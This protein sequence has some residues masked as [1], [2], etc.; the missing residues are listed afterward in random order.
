M[1]FP[2]EIHPVSR[3]VTAS[4]IILLGYHC[5]ANPAV[6]F[7][8]FGM[9]LFPL[10]S[11]FLIINSIL[12]F[13][14]YNSM[15]AMCDYLLFFILFI[16]FSKRFSSLHIKPFLVFT[17]IAASIISLYGIYQHFFGFKMLARFLG[18]SGSLFPEIFLRKVE[19]GRVFST[20][21]LPAAL[22]GFL[23]MTIPLTLFLVVISQSRRS[24]VFYL[25]LLIIQSVGLF[26]SFSLGA[27]IAL[28]LSLLVV[29]WFKFRRRLSMVIALSSVFVVAA[30]IFFSYRNIALSRFLDTDSPL[31]LRWGNWKAALLMIRDHPL[32][33]VGN[34]SFGIAFSQYREWWMNESHFAHDSFLQIVA[35]NGLFALPFL[36]IFLFLLLKGAVNA[37]NGR[38]S[39]SLKPFVSFSCL[40]FIFHN[41]FD[42]TFYLPSVAFLFFSLC[43]LALSTAPREDGE[44]RRF[45]DTSR[46]IFITLVTLSFLFFISSFLGDSCF[47]SARRSRERGDFQRTD[48]LLMRAKIFNPLKS[49][50]RIYRAQLLVDADNDAKDQVTALDEARSAISLDPSIPYYYKVLS[51][52]S[53]LR[54]EPIGAYSAIAKASEL[55]P[56]DESYRKR[57]DLLW[58]S[59]K[60]GE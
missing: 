55:Y 38:A 52:I 13:S 7:R 4:L 15:A 43:G 36:A 5:A 19:S 53:V 30:F 57:K 31:I 22:A 33:G 56:A 50:Y 9:T 58:K 37:E 28:F 51:D 1:L 14:P 2:P 8:N 16:V 29:I 18:E 25:F 47:E 41:L 3:I 60:I 34:A 27:L 21:A 49:E 35:E 20:F 26:L 10:I 11:I 12:S 17:T 6:S 54:G 59:M 44:R 23:L 24:R 48:A 45:L 39:Q 40:T 46:L 42:F 32:F